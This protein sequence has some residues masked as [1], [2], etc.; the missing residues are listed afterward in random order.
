ML[1]YKCISFHFLEY[2]ILKQM[3]FFTKNVQTLCSQLKR[4]QIT[5]LYKT[6]NPK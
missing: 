6:L 4:E 2:S 3:S 1:G 5:Y